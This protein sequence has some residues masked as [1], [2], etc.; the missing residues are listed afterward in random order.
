[1]DKI[2]QIC[3]IAVQTLK[4]DLRRK[5]IFILFLFPP[6]LSYAAT[7]FTSFMP[8]SEKEFLTDIALSS[9]SLFTLLM[10][11]FMTSDL[12]LKEVDRG[13]LYFFTS[14]PVQVSALILGK[15]LGCFLIL[16]L[17]T[18]GMSIFMLILF[19]L[20]FHFF[21]SDFLKASLLLLGQMSI[22]TAMGV[23]GSTFLSKFTNLS[24]LLL[25]YTLGHLGDYAEYFKVHQDHGVGLFKWLLRWIPDFSKF[26]FRNWLILGVH[27]NILSLAKAYLYA[28]FFSGLLLFLGACILKKRFFR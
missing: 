19:Y 18:L 8:G 26:E 25:I 2:S 21:Y 27:L 13:T 28:F 17:A 23:W 20:K 14:N 6:I 4:E 1:M 7:V 11:A 16:I 24:S 12:F 9:V 15:W 10:T 22:L 3:A 5:T